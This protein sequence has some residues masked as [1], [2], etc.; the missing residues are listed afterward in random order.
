M[1]Q[2]FSKNSHIARIRLRK[3]GPR[4]CV[5]AQV[6][7]DLAHMPETTALDVAILKMKER[8]H[9]DFPVVQEILVGSFLFSELLF[10]KLSPSSI[11]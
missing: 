6:H 3:Y 9:K 4:V 7:V 8:I 1:R 11:F 5:D 2:F 10:A